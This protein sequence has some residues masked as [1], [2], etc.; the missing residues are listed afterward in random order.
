MS[1]EILSSQVDLSYKDTATTI[2]YDIES[3][4]GL[5]TIVLMD[6]TSVSCIFYG[7]KHLDDIVTDDDIRAS[8]REYI[9]SDE[10]KLDS[11]PHA[12]SPDDITYR[13]LRVREGDVGSLADMHMAI[14]DIIHCQPISALGYNR[15]D[16]RWG[17][18]TQE[19]PFVQYAGWNSSAYD[20]PLLIIISLALNS[21]TSITA[22]TPDVIRKFSDTLINANVPSWR[23]GQYVQDTLYRAPWT[24]MT[25]KSY[26]TKMREAIVSDGHIDWAKIAKLSEDDGAENRFPPGLKK[27]MA[28]FGFDIIEDELVSGEVSAPSA[29]QVLNL[30]YYNVNDVLGTRLLS[31]NSMIQGLLETRDSVRRLYPYT[32]AKAVGTSKRLRPL[33]RD[34]TA[35]NLVGSVLIGPE[36]VRPEDEDTVKGAFGI[37]LGRVGNADDLLPPHVHHGGRNDGGQRAEQHRRQKAEAQRGQDVFLVDPLSLFLARGF[38]LGLFFGR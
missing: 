4:P 38:T 9:A 11:F 13:L 26:D 14:L 12:S 29:R 31:R 10:T 34:C 23:L 35:A 22:T 19:G 32:S 37:V 15:N 17:E 33:E 28:R 18:G 7:D 6:D 36:R 20:L 25:K 3:I 30:V 5:F 8:M 27:E 2:T 24:D 16:Y 21:S 1:P